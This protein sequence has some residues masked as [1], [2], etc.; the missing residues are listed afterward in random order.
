M[1]PLPFAKLVMLF[2]EK[3]VR[4]RQALT[5]FKRNGDANDTCPDDAIIKVFHKMDDLLRASRV[6]ENRASL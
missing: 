1:K 3:Y 6:N 5:Q 4:S 2:N